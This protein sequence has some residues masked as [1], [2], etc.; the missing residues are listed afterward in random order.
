MFEPTDMMKKRK[1][2]RDGV[3]S[4]VRDLEALLDSRYSSKE[5]RTKTYLEGS[6]LGRRVRVRVNSVSDPT[7]GLRGDWQW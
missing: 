4:F 3:A 1:R 5:S 2:G 6:H 7:N